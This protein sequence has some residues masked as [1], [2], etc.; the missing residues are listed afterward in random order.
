MHSCK[1]LSARKQSLSF[2][3]IRTL[4][5]LFRQEPTTLSQ[6]GVLDGTVRALEDQES[7]QQY[8]KSKAWP[9]VWFL[10]SL[11]SRFNIPQIY[12]LTSHK[13]LGF[14][15]IL[16]ETFYFIPLLLQIDTIPKKYFCQ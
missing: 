16:H 3:G 5:I 8:L 11:R 14:K 4:A 9:M 13:S 2:A 15:Y 1:G 12:T 10:G 6:R 7:S